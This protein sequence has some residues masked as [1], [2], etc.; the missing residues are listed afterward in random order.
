M[1]TNYSHKQDNQELLIYRGEEHIATHDLIAEK[2]TFTSE[3]NEKFSNMVKKYLK[4]VDTSEET[5]EPKVKPPTKK[6][7]TPL[8]EMV[9]ALTERVKF[10][11]DK[12]PKIPF[13][14]KKLERFSDDFDDSKG[15]HLKGREGDLTPEYV[16]W[17]KENMPK[18]VFEKRYRGRN[19]K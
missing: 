18:G 3:Q 12:A 16:A 10:L 4:S 2:T 5:P 11:E 15:A 13:E 1:A 19:L 14:H 6:V 9:E 7:E 8:A 17:A